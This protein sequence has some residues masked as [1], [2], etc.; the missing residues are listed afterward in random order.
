MAHVEGPEK[1]EEALERASANE[2]VEEVFGQSGN[3]LQ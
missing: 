3:A 2:K 1:Y